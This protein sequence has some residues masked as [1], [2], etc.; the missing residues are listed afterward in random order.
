MQS[1]IYPM[2]VMGITQNY[3]GRYSHY[4]ES[5]AK[6]YI[7]YPI[8]DAGKDSGRDYFY[9]PCDLVVKRIYGV[10]NKGTNTIWLESCN[11][12]KLANGKESVVTIR[13]THPGDDD[14][15]KIKV[16]QKF[17]QYAQMFHEG[18]DGQATG[19]HHHICVSM[20]NFNKLYNNGWIKNSNGY[21]VTAPKAIKP[22]DAFFVDKKFTNI[23]NNGGLKFKDLPSKKGQ[24]LYLPADA[25]TWRVYKLDVVPHAG[26]EC[27]FLTPAK[28]G[29]LTYDII[30]WTNYKDVCVINTKKFGIVQIYVAS[31]TGAI[32]K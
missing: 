24:V 4:G 12:V 30:K 7:C 3:N 27:G 28:F 5:H 21:W 25:E 15:S 14:L 26:N 16:G 8:D 31:S 10:K 13:V 22:E 11:K 23:K 32:I 20:C 9:A 1:L 29:G 17:K 19:Y 18:K 6:D 2:K